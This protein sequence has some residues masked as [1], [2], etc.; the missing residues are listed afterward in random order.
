MEEINTAIQS[1]LD[2]DNPETEEYY[3]LKEDNFFVTL[4]ANRDFDAST[5]I[6]IL[7]EYNDD[8]IRIGIILMRNPL[9]WIASKRFLQYPAC[10]TDT[11]VI[12]FLPNKEKEPD[13]VRLF[14]KLFSKF[15]LVGT[16]CEIAN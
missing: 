16:F 14:S 10:I 12:V 5:G 7:H 11:M 2:S 9:S 6:N 8:I 3:V 15:G 4:I 13:Q 1:L